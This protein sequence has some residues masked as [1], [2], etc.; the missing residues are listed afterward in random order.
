MNAYNA[1]AQD[2][3]ER[4]YLAV[5]ED[6]EHWRRYLDKPIIDETILIDNLVI[7]GDPQIVKIDGLYVMFFSDI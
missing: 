3:K 7:S 1:K 4:I 5:S 6:G 2:N